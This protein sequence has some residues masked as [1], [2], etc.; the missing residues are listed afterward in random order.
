MNTNHTPALL[1]AL[2]ALLPH[3]PGH[4]TDDISGRP[5]IV[6]A[7]AAIAAATEPQADNSAVI[8]RARQMYANCGHSDDIE[9][10]SNAQVSETD[11]GTWVQAWVWVPNEEDDE[12]EDEESECELC[13]ARVAH[14]IGTPNGHEICQECFDNG[15]E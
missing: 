3:V 8:D 12:D 2:E 15:A 11:D 10:D 7:R 6:Q 4:M 1:A 14:V 5:W 13:G 9:I